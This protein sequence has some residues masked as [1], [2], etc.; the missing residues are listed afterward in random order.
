PT[1][2]PE[3]LSMIAI[4]KQWLES[5]GCRVLLG[6]PFNLGVDAKGRVTVM[7]EP[8]DLIIRHYKTDWWGERETIW[9]NQAPFPDPDRLARELTLLLEAENEGRITIVNPFGAVVTQNKL[10]MAL[11]WERQ[12]LFSPQAR[13]WIAEYIP[14]TRALATLGSTELK[15]ED[16]VLKS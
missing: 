2:L 7:G 10:S 12:E 11:M 13:Q 16:W 6:S 14:E 1:D 15:Q 4:Y 3:D 8:V 9:A 5:R